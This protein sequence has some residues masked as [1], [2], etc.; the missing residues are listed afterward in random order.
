MT[1]DSALA[2]AMIYSLYH[3]TLTLESAL[4]QVNS[5]WTPVTEVCIYSHTGR[6]PTSAAATI[7]TGVVTVRTHGMQTRRVHPVHD[8]R[9]TR[10]M[11]AGVNTSGGIVLLQLK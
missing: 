6:N 10:G 11:Q 4:P 9:R 5:K 2:V 7:A 3:L 8:Q 1:A